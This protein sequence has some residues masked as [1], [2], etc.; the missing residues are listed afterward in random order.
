M[1]FPLPESIIIWHSSHDL[2]DAIPVFEAWEMQS[3]V[4]F[5]QHIVILHLHTDLLDRLRDI[6][7]LFMCRK[8]VAGITR[9]V[10]LQATP[11][12]E[13]P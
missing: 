13:F 5:L 9:V 3:S 12:V 6:I 4:F 10:H 8:C 1:Q 7:G 11:S 2:L